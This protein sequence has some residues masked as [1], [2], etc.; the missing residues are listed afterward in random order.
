M[1]SENQY[2]QSYEHLPL[3]STAVDLDEDSG[4]LN[5]LSDLFSSSQGDII[6]CELSE[7]QDVND[8]VSAIKSSPLRSLMLPSPE[9]L[10]QMAEDDK[11]S[12][13]FIDSPQHNNF[14][15]GNSGNGHGN[16]TVASS[17]YISTELST[18]Q[19]AENMMCFVSPAK[20]THDHPLKKGFVFSP[21]EVN[22]YIQILGSRG[23][24]IFNNI[25]HVDSQL[26]TPSPNKMIRHSTLA[27]ETPSST[28]FHKSTAKNKE[29]R[30]VP[31][32]TLHSIF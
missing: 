21:S 11:L 20:S 10:N 4:E 24:A 30:P 31:V 14:K 5:D 23:R 22:I 19:Q 26:F 1:Y 15:T 28:E 2:E 13:L 8:L 7:I 16:Y 25:C 12:Q 9:K 27:Y 29:V 18:M 6:N 32:C 3:N 17:G